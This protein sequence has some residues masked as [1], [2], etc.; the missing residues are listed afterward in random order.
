MIRVLHVVHAL[1]RR[2]GLSNCIMNYYRYIDRTKIQFDFLYFREV[3]DNFC[4][5]IE[6]LGGRCFKLEEPSLSRSFIKKTNQFFKEHEGEWCFLHCHAL[7]AVS[8]FSKIAKKNG[9]SA[10]I[11]HS[12]STVYGSGLFKKVRN[13]VF[14]QQA[15]QLS[16]YRLACSKEAGNFM[17]GKNKEFFLLNNA[18]DISVYRSA[19]EKR[20]IV[21]RELSL[22]NAFVLGHV[23]S[24]AASKNHKFLIEIFNEVQKTVPNAKLL[25]VGGEGIAAGS[26]LA[27][28]K[29]KVVDLDLEDKVLFLG[30]RQDVPCLMSA[31]DA[32]VFPSLFEGFGLVLVEAQASGLPCTA[33]DRVPLAAK[34]TDLVSYLPLES[35]A[36]AWAEHILN[37][38]TQER[39]VAIESF[40][41]YNIDTQ[42]QVLE[43]MYLNMAK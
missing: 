2:G 18:I 16:D 30:V 11:A 7:F 38:R 13:F 41:R 12:H 39:K 37:H 27:Q 3:E 21:R 14:I 10:V 29:Q 1:T 5:E 31:M 35:G 17:F 6:Q 42:K 40:D 15:A 25:L 28:M 8:V 23:G 19:Q 24:F 22:E 36:K 9:V 20:A 33:S 32:F 34:C 26:T 43:D 4:E